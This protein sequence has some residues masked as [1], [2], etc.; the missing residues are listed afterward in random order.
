MSVR[1]VFAEGDTVA[2]RYRLVRLLGE[3]G[4]GRVYLAQRS[5]MGGHVALKILRS[6]VDLPAT[7]IERFRRE[8]QAAAQL[9]SESVVRVLD[10]GVTDDGTPFI[11][12]ER[13][14]GKTLAQNLGDHGPLEL[15]LIHISTP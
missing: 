11:V 15:S 14:S 13:V 2:G 1:R 6:D 12:M 5:E 3:G 8:A 10:M 7:S 9:K 4:M